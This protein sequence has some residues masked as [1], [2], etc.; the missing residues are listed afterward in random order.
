MNIMVSDELYEVHAGD[1]PRIAALTAGRRVARAFFHYQ[2]AFL[3]KGGQAHQDQFDHA[4][5]CLGAIAAS[6][7]SLGKKSAACRRA[8]SRRLRALI[9]DR[10]EGLHWSDDGE[11]WWWDLLDEAAIEIEQGGSS[12]EVQYDRMI[13]VSAVPFRDEVCAEL[14][15][16]LEPNMREIFELGARLEEGLCRPDVGLYLYEQA[17]PS[18][19]S[20]ETAAG[21][22]TQAPESGED[23]QPEEKDDDS[24]PGTL[25]SNEAAKRSGAPFG[26]VSRKPGE[27]P[28]DLAW[29][30]DLPGHWRLAGL[31]FGNWSWFQDG[32]RA[33]ARKSLGPDQIR[34]IVNGLVDE[35]FRQCGADGASDLV[36]KVQ[37]SPPR[38][39]MGNKEF[40]VEPEGAALFDAL[41]R[42]EGL[43]VRFEE[44][45]VRAYPDVFPS[46][47]GKPCR[48]I[49]KLPPELKKLVVS[50]RG[51]G[52]AF[53]DNVKVAPAVA[54]E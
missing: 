49:A 51:R 23:D 43:P 14:L 46:G 34:E 20:G 28:P 33:C 5:K 50:E 37:L 21:D 8:A 30:E 4:K 38:V 53:A 40:A 35:A 54:E 42:S 3:I 17:A 48:V 29:F 52:T 11:S 41:W 9:D 1:T 2:Q 31:E 18:I 47:H 24:D 16:L 32:A 13:R 25:S 19:G 36:T 10:L 15:R 45:V 22:D 39:W 44:D 26:D 27:L 7:L 12:F 6:S